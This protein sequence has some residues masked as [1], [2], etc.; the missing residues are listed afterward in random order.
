MNRNRKI[1]NGKRA[2]AGAMV[3]VMTAGAVGVCE[4]YHPG[5][6]V[7]AEEETAEILEKTA[8]EA[9]IG[10]D[11]GEREDG[12]AK[13]GTFKEESVYVKAD[14]GGRADKATVTEW[15][16][17]PENG[18]FLDVSGLKEIKNIKGEEEYV[19]GK[20]KDL[21]WRSEGNDIYYQG[22]TEEALPV[23]VNI[24]Y[25][26]DGKPVKAEELSGKDGKVEIHIDYENHAKQSVEIGGED[27]EMYTPFTMVTAMMLPTD[28]YTNVTVDNGKIMSDADKNIVIG[29]GFPGL[30]ENLKLEDTDVDIPESIT[31]TADV[32]SA[33]VGPTV[34]VAS[35]ELMNEFDLSDV[36]DF[37]SLEDSVRELEDASA[38]LADGSNEAADGSKALADGT[39]EAA[40][41][42]KELAEG[43]EEAAAGAEGLEEGTKSAAKGAQELAA[44]TKSAAEGAKEVEAGSKALEAGVNELN[45]KSG[46]LACGMDHLAAGVKDYTNGVSSLADGSKNLKDGA[47]SLRSNA[48][49]LAGSLAQISNTMDQMV[50]SGGTVSAAE[51]YGAA[52][53]A[54]AAANNTLAGAGGSGECVVTGTSEAAA[55]I[56]GMVEGVDAAQ[57]QAVIDGYVGAVPVGR[58][59]ASAQIAYAMAEITEAQNSLYAAQNAE[60]DVQAAVRTKEEQLKQLAAGLQSAS[61]GAAAL[62]KGAEELS[63]GIG[64]VSAGA[65]QLAGRNKE[66]TG[67]VDQLAAGVP[68]LTAGVGE[69]AQGA[70]R[71]SKG[72]GALSAGNQ[73]L[74]AGAGAL[75]AGNQ[76]LL[77][78]ADALSAGNQK[79]AEGAGALAVGSRKLSQGAA[80]LSAGSQELAAGAGALADGNQQLAKGMAEFKSS[81]I[82]KLADVFDQDIRTVRARIDTMSE[83]GKNYKSFAGIKEGMDGSTKFII[84]TEGVK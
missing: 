83:L 44:G 65:D 42:S 82:D 63:N 39:K 11:A 5:R 46:E 66:L 20:G 75:L 40:D 18:E 74:A 58:S 35:A 55:A 17:N 59:D 43:S 32:K 38:K 36:E 77:T 25:K 24:S 72:A 60:A 41:G 45:N 80:A 1:R 70:S 28:E 31:I 53:N 6:E 56:A 4:Y 22:T 71:L 33:S 67:G 2:V 48:E 50:N 57:I 68:G 27:V 13:A 61:A 9:L 37:D 16:K 34:T 7:M 3:A 29:L 19:K 49:M 14:A 47:D 26:L 62:T 76:Q 84:E 8:S 78:G 54:L 79:L 15:I 21:K 69:L 64:A 52:A 81:G 10:T 12:T 23:D 51:S 30:T 73:E